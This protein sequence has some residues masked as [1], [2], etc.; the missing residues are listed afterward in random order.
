MSRSAHDQRTKVAVLIEHACAKLGVRPLLGSADL[1][2]EEG[3]LGAGYG[4]PTP[5][6]QE[7]VDL[8]A[9]Q[10]GIMLDPVYTG[11]AMAGL[12]GG[13]RTGRFGAADRIVFMHTGGAMALFA[14]PEIFEAERETTP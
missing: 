3:V 8:V 2:L 7:A 5:A 10:E 14:Y 4:Q 12:I 11:K 6:M 13:I 1:V 9:S